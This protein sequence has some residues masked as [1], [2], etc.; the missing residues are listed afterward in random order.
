[1]VRKKLKLFREAI[2][3]PVSGVDA[4]LRNVQPNVPKVR[5]CL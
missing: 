4:V 5:I 2:D 3:Q 1:M